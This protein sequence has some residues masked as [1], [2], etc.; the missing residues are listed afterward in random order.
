LY[1]PCNVQAVRARWCIAAHNAL[2]SHQH[3]YKPTKKIVA[4]T[5]NN[6]NIKRQM[7]RYMNR[8]WNTL[9]I[10]VGFLYGV[11]C[12]YHWKLA[13]ASS[14]DPHAMFDP[15]Q[16]CLAHPSL[17]ICWW[18]PAHAIASWAWDTRVVIGFSCAGSFPRKTLLR[19]Q[20]SIQ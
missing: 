3:A 12:G 6:F 19:P 20:R 13:S 4:L 11:I 15:E 10:L 7:D 18:S 14:Y 2:L 16:P 17:T 8:N 1:A 5:C 9:F